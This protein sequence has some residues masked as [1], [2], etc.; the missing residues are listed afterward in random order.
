MLKQHY[1]C[2]FKKTQ[3]FEPSTLFLY[4]VPIKQNAA[5]QIQWYIQTPFVAIEGI[6][7][8]IEGIEHKREIYNLLNPSQYRI[9][10]TTHT[11]ESLGRC[12]V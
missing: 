12:K 11:T 5:F 6:Q 9:A 2:C 4:I 8:H 7:A 10:Y 1:T 3:I